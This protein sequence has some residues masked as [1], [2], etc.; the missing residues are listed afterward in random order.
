MKIYDTKEITENKL[1][2]IYAWVVSSK[3]YLES[4]YLKESTSSS[5]PYKFEI[6]KENNKYKVINIYTPRDGSYYKTDMEEL[7]PK[8]V[9]DKMKSV[10]I[11]GTV[12]ELLDK[13]LNQAK[14]YFN[15]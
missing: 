14:E 12:K 2:Y 15:K 1:Y 6:E 13:N 3:Y 11:D 8:N 7:F 10:Q 5:I 9:I 4:N